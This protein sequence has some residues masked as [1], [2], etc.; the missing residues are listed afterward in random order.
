[1]LILGLAYYGYERLSSNTALLDW[2]AGHLLAFPPGHLWEGT[3][4]RAAAG[5]NS[6]PA[7]D[8]AEGAVGR[9]SSRS[10][11]PVIGCP[12]SWPGLSLY[13]NA[14]YFNAATMI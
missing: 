4:N 12:T 5:A 10:P 3:A 14:A 9:A 11:A 13:F 2:P 8:T 7:V 6:D 1:M